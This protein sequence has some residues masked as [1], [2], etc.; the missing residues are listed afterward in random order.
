MVFKLLLIFCCIYDTLAHYEGLVCCQSGCTSEE[1]IANSSCILYKAVRKKTVQ[2][3][4][5]THANE[6]LF[7]CAAELNISSFLALKDFKVQKIEN[8][9]TNTH[10]D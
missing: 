3:R 7:H 8:M 10:R 1:E 2:Q 5:D 4:Q 6:D 9:H